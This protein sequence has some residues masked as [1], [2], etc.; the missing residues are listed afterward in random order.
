VSLN[1]PEESLGT[2][3]GVHRAM[4]ATGAFIGP[5]LAVLVLAA[6]RDRFD[7]LFVI[8]FCFALLGLGVLTLFVSSVPARTEAPAPERIPFRAA[9]GLLRDTRLRAL[10]IAGAGLSLITISDGF[11][12]L[13]MQERTGMEAGLVPLLFVGTS[14]SYL[15]LAVPAGRL[16]DRWGRR[17][18]YLAGHALVAAVYLVM[19]LPAFDVPMLILSVALLGGYYAATDGVLAA[20][21]SGLVPPSLRGSGLALLA[22]VTSVCRLAGSVVVGAIWTW[23]GPST[24]IAG[25][26]VMMVAG[27]A[28]SDRVLRRIA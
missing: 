24:A 2:A 22:T 16:A 13:R 15:L 7:L 11:L 12:Y 23:Y 14:L 20:L 5:L 25:F 26:A 4:D 17:R 3:F 27:L 18:V 1:T 6:F 10:A 28:L 8:S 9:L 21:A 19:L